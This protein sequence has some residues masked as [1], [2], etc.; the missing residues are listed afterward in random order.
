M[1]N[2]ANLE[3][4]TWKSTVAPGSGSSASQRACGGGSWRWLVVSL[5][6]CAN[7][8]AVKERQRGHAELMYWPGNRVRPLLAVA[9]SELAGIS[10]VPG[11]YHHCRAS[12]T[13]LTQ[14][15]MRINSM[16]RSL[17]PVYMK[18][19][20]I[21]NSKKITSKLAPIPKHGPSGLDC[22]EVSLRV[23]FI[24]VPL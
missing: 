16:D 15:I 8:H 5:V 7:I 3:P 24:R 9:E 6:S 18:L 12:A 22:K 19:H 21:A 20:C 17:L 11:M 13:A 14:L 2:S 23:L 1:F 10:S 4:G